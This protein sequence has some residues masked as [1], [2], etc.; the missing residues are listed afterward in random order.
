MKQLGRLAR[1]RY[2]DQGERASARGGFIPAHDT[3]CS[4]AS[5]DLDQRIA[6]HRCLRARK[7]D[8]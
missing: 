4:K 1:S 2:H 6:K 8:P 7:P 5:T 3:G